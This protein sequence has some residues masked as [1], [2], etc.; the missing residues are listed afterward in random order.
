M[1]MQ[2]KLWRKVRIQSGVDILQVVAPSVFIQ[3]IRLRVRSVEVTAAGGS[4]EWLAH[5][6]TSPGPHQKLKWLHT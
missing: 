3:T 6:K 5:G 2:V 4:S 1:Q